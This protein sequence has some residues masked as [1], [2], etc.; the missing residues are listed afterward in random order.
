MTAHKTLAVK[1][2]NEVVAQVAANE[3][4]AVAHIRDDMPRLLL[5]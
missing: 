2:A 4:A 1:A 3:A 5:R